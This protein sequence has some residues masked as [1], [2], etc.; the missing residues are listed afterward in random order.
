MLLLN[1]GSWLRSRWK[2]AIEELLYRL[3]TEDRGRGVALFEKLM[4]GCPD[5]LCTHS[6]AEFLYYGSYRHFSRIK[7]FIQAR[8]NSR[9]EDCAQRGAELACLAATSSPSVL[10]SNEALDIARA[11]AEN[12]V[13]GPPAL[14]RGAAKI[15]AHN[16]DSGQSAFCT[17]ELSRLLDDEDAEVRRSVADAFSRVRN[18]HDPEVREFVEQ[19]VAS[20]ALADGEDDLAE[21]LWEYGPDDPPWALSVLEAMLS[22]SQA[23]DSIRRTGGEELVRLVLRVYTHPTSDRALRER[24]MDAFDKLMERYAYEAQRALNEWDQR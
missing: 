22:N 13:T 19:F 10:G 5:L 2:G 21:F 9:L 6:T 15:Y 8:L 11:L 16:I 12:A 3:L 1:P 7:P 4:E 20:R 23:R 18:V 14:Q 24:A 17:H